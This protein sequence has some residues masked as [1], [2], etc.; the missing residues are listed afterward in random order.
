VSDGDKSARDEAAERERLKQFLQWRHALGRAPRPRRVTRG[1]VVSAAAIVL[2]IGTAAIAFV[3][4]SES[5]RA[6]SGADRPIPAALS[7]R[8]PA[9]RQPIAEPPGQWRE[10]P[11]AVQ[12]PLEL[13]PRPARRLALERPPDVRPPAASPPMAEAR[14]APERPGHP[15]E[16]PAAPL[17]DGSYD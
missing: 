11:T 7:P 1:R 10:D 2:L 12:F 3:A 9:A 5:R 17:D 4:T 8:R 6:P 14:E 13:P 15:E 16:P